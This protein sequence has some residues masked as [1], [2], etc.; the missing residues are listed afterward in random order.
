LSQ[1]PPA[2]DARV[3]SSPGD[4]PLGSAAGRVDDAATA[5]ARRLAG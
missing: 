2:L 1:F 3:S 5:V 4:A